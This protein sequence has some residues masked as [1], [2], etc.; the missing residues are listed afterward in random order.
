M[1]IY[2]LEKTTLVQANLQTTWNFFSDPRNLAAITPRD[3]DFMIMNEEK[4]PLKVHVGLLISYTVKPIAGIKM[5]WLSEIK[6]VNPPY[7]FIDEQRSGPYAFWYHEHYFKAG[8]NEN[9]TRMTDKVSY[10]IP[11]GFIGRIA[12]KL[13]VASKL[14]DIFNHRETTI[15]R[16]FSK[17]M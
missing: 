6:A 7:Y 5:N 1:K 17:T 14:N 4:L 11:Y 2:Q 3:M 9:E 16:I 8:N 13:F 12:Q 10:A 15:Q